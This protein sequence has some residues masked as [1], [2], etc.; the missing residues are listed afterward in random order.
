[1]KVG[2]SAMLLLRGNR[3]GRR[4][5]P[6]LFAASSEQGRLGLRPFVPILAGLRRG[7]PPGLQY[8]FEAS[9]LHA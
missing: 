2:R 8:R 6:L 3:R 4:R 7:G 9:N 5:R 1:M